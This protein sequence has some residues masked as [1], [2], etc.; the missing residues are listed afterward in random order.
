[1]TK[2]ILNLPSISPEDRATIGRHFF[3]RATL[4][5]A[6]GALTRWADWLTTTG[7]GAPAWLTDLIRSPS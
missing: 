1:M 7:R 6:R 5:E 2:P 4:A 3:C